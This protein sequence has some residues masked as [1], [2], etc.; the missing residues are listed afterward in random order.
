MLLDK[1]LD[2]IISQETARQPRMRIFK[3]ILFLITIIGCFIYNI[4][5][6]MDIGVGYNAQNII[7]IVFLFLGMLFFIMNYQSNKGYFPHKCGNFIYS[8]CVL[9]SLIAFIFYIVVFIVVVVIQ[10]AGYPVP[11]WF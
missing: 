9:V 8:I 7:V 4:I 3:N 1:I 11:R 6:D 10:L 2:K 5:I